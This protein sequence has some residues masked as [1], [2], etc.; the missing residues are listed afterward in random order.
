MRRGTILQNAKRR[1]GGAGRRSKRREEAGRASDGAF[2][3][4]FLDFGNR[5]RRREALGATLAQ[6]MMVWQR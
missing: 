2:G 6:F 4:H 5:A 3:L 1:P